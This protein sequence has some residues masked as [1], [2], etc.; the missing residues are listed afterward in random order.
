MTQAQVAVLGECMLEVSLATSASD[1]MAAKVPANLS[2]GGDVLNT[3][4]YLSRLSC[5]VDFVSALGD[6]EMSSWL[7][8]QWRQEGV[9]CDLIECMPKQSPGLYLISTDDEG[10]RSF[11]YWREQSPA[12]KMFD[13]PAKARILFDRL[14]DYPWLYFTGISL[15]ILSDEGR[16]LLLGFLDE[17]RAGGGKVAF[18]SNF[19]P[20][21]WADKLSAQAVFNQVYAKTDLAMLTLDDEI[22]LF[23]EGSVEAHAERLQRSGIKEL[24]LKQGPDG[25]L[26]I[27]DGQSERVAAQMVVPVDTTS[28]GDSFNAGYLSQLVA[29][30]SS[31]EAAQ[32]AHQLAGLV[33][34]HRGAI[35]GKSVTEALVTSLN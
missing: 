24:V 31:V 2:Y 30:R 25:C 3:A 22:L 32:V 18:D 9:G 29:G 15:A 8:A 17:Y 4:V 14:R 6:D 21:L 26:I 7:L 11:S 35:V 13:D 34:Q 5:A 12:R 28:A 33:I 27:K 10:E 19:R 20:R 1:L 23:G 16:A